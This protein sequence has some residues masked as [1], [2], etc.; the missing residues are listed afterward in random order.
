MITASLRAAPTDLDQTDLDQKAPAR[1]RA[2][3]PTAVLELRI[4]ESFAEIEPEWRAFERDAQ[5]SVYQGFRWLELWHRHIGRHE[6][7][8]LLLV[9]GTRAGK[10]AFIWPMGVWR[11]GPLRVARW[12]G[13]KFNNYNLGLWRSD[14][15]AAMTRDDLAATLADL[16]ARA[17]IDTFELLNQ[18]VTWDG[19]ANPFAEIA[20][21]PSPSSSHAMDLQPDFTA[22]Y[23]GR[24]SSRSRRTLRRKRENMEKAGRPRLIH[25]RDEATVL[26][27]VEALVEQRN[28][29]AATAG[30]PSVFADYGA[31]E[32]TRDI[33]LD[34]LDHRGGPRMEAH[35]LEVGGVIRATYVGGILHG[36]Y[37]CFLN[38]FRD[39][40]LTATSPGEQLLY[41]VV[42]SCCRRGMTR[43]DL[44]IGEERYKSSWCDADPLF[45]SFIPVTA[46]GR[47]HARLRELRQVLKRA[48]KG[49][50]VLWQAVKK[51]RQLRSRAGV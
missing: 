44:G 11:S 38:S 35:A 19:Q 31:L 45:D 26:R 7:E 49:N 2:A 4:V 10:P 40:E 37:S 12:L 43:L 30:I 18:P 36:R 41:D 17:R 27:I 39:D 24:R 9:V 16:A 23:E 5:M 13:G 15:L 47:L 28:A 3:A 42:E 50:P 32:L 6:V 48:I 21:V 34:S 1:D 14:E 20:A 51:A 25:A 46:A 8:R 33:L 22:L 29:R